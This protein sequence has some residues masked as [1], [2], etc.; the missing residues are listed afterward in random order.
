MEWW[1]KLKDLLPFG[2]HVVHKKEVIVKLTKVNILELEE[3]KP[4]GV[5]RE[6]SF[7]RTEKLDFFHLLPNGTI[8]HTPGD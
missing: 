2:F 7:F 1:N 5:L 6:K 3:C 4:K 8:S